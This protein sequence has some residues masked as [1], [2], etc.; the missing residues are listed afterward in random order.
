MNSSSEIFYPKKYFSATRKDGSSGGKLVPLG[1]IEAP[2]PPE[3]RFSFGYNS[4]PGASN[5]V[6]F[7]Q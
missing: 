1:S 4:K 7:L 5:I 6:S 3:T 2:F